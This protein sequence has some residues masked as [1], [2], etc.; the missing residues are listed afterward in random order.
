MEAPAAA[1]EAEPKADG[2]EI[3]IGFAKGDYAPR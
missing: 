1:A 3:Y 2:A